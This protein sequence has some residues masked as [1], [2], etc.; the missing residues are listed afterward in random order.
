[1]VF[2]N[3]FFSRELVG[4]VYVLSVK[5]TTVQPWWGPVGSRSLGLSDFQTIDT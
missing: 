4:E 3:E 5:A 1:M 2:Q